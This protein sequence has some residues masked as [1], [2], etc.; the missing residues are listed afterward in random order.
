MAVKSKTEDLLIKKIDS[1]VCTFSLVDR[2]IYLSTPALQAFR[3]RLTIEDAEEILEFVYARTGTKKTMRKSSLSVEEMPDLLNR[4]I[5]IIEEKRS[6][7][8]LKFAGDELQKLLDLIN[9]K[10][11]I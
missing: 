11:E 6:R 2:C 4:V 3:L 9:K 5:R 10:L 8:P 1:W 7:I